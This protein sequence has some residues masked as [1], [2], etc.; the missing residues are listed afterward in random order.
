MKNKLIITIVGIAILFGIV[1]SGIIIGLGIQQGESSHSQANNTKRTPIQAWESEKTKLD[2]FSDIAISL[3]YC[4]LF[5]LP[6]DGYYLEYRMD[7]SCE[8]PEYGVNGNR[9]YFQ[10]GATQ[11]KYCTGWHLFFNSRYSSANQGPFYVNLYV[12]KE[13]Y[14]NL[15]EISS[16]SGN[17]ELED[18][19]AKNIDI[20]AQYGNL[21]SDNFSGDD[22]SVIAESGNIELGNID[23]NTL[24]INN[25]YG[26]ITAGSCKSARKT[27]LK[28]ESG[29]LTLSKLE[30]D[31]LT[32]SNEYGG[33][34]VNEI[35]LKQSDIAIESGNL[36]LLDATLGDTEIRNSY[37]NVTLNL[38]GDISDYNY[39]L[40]ASYG[41]IKLDGKTLPSDEDGVSRYQKDYGKDMDIIIGSDSGNITIR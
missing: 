6:A 24:E 23:C 21:Q 16:E 11:L 14:F 33:C 17:I 8:E 19:Q 13:Q 36:K 27:S 9:F 7:G 30:T 25:Q 4:D 31:S 2:E 28:L 12:P 10:E 39:D 5:I 20:H 34:S 15:L 1:C 22:I 18:I 41:T 37:G 38:A 29:D 35:T 40:N 3:S 26:N 32:L